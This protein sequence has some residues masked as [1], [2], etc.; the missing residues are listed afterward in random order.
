M[1]KK[2]DLQSSSEKYEFIVDMCNFGDFMDNHH[3]IS[4]SHNIR[5]NYNDSVSSVKDELITED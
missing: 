1:N 4:D 2:I 5:N 3:S